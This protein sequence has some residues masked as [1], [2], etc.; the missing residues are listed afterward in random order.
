M[1]SLYYTLDMCK[2]NYVFNT[3]HVDT[4][5]MLDSSMMIRILLENQ[6]LL[7]T[8]QEYRDPTFK[9]TLNCYSVRSLICVWNVEKD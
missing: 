9:M 7:K 8:P 6:Y 3:Y 2:A 5:T 4:E 1:C